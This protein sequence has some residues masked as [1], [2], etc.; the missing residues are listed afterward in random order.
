MSCTLYVK[1]CMQCLTSEFFLNALPV[2]ERRA[3]LVLS[4]ESFIFK[5]S[6]NIRISAGCIKVKTVSM[7]KLVVKAQRQC[8]LFETDFGTVFQM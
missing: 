2:L 3:A 6:S 4:L 8:G 1:F 5:A 7:A